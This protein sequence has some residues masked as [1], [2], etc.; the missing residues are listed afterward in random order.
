MALA[1]LTGPV[2]HTMTRA[3]H[4]DSDVITGPKKQLTRQDTGG[5]G[6]ADGAEGEGGWVGRWVGLGGKRTMRRR[7]STVTVERCARAGGR[8]CQGERGR[9]GDGAVGRETTTSREREGGRERER[10]GGEMGKERA[11]TAET[12]G[13]DLRRRVM[14]HDDT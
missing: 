12:E 5:R 14:R 11:S 3:A 6:V 9:G 4:G 2:Q 13:R 7:A 8:S 1:G 10:E